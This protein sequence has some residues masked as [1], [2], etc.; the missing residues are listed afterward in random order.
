MDSDEAKKHA[1]EED[2][3]AGEW[4]NHFGSW[5]GPYYITAWEPDV[6]VVLEANPNYYLEQPPIKKIIYQ[7]VPNSA[8]RIALLKAG[9]SLQGLP[10]GPTRV[11]IDQPTPAQLETMRTAIQDLT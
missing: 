10:A 9:L 6:Q 7:V 3:W 8:D 1:T 2:P 5:Y 4:V 11:A